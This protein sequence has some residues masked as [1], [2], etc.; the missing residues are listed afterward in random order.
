V[1]APLV[2]HE[3]GEALDEAR[4]QSLVE[5]YAAM[6]HAYEPVPVDRVLRVLDVAL[7]AVAAVL[8]APVLAVA[9]VSIALTSGRPVLYRGARVGRAGSVYTMYKLRTLRKDAEQRIGPFDAG[10]TLEGLTATE[11]TRLG[12][13]LRA[14]KVD[15]IPQLWN[16][17][18]GDMSLVGPRPIRPA[19][20]EELCESIPMYWQRLVIRPG[21]TGFAQTRLGRVETW[22]EKLSHDLEYIADRS[23]HLYFS[24]LARTAWNLLFGRR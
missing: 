6:A 9:V 12:R 22:A 11:Q 23:V 8:A 1:T 5:Q 14:T 7:S 10:P 16:V 2:A 13:V 18:R 20:F 4:E 21:L 24:T 15:E 19:F 17:L 3:P